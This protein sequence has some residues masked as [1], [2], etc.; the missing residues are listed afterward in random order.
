MADMEDIDIWR[1]A[2]QMR[3]VYGEDAG[4]EAA[5]RADKAFDQGDIVGCKVWKRIVLAIG[6]LERNVPKTGEALN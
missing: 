2:E 5:V 4:I 1:A 6:E 3:T